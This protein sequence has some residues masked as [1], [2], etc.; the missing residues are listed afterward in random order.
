MDPER[1]L[2]GPDLVPTCKWSEN[3]DGAWE[4]DCNEI[5][6]FTND[7]DGPTANGFRHCPY[8]GRYAKE[9]RQS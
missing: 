2:G 3:E 7:G 8:C 4:T 6:E 1:I 9:I 5:F